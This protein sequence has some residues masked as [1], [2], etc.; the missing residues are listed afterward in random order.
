M[1]SFQLPSGLTSHLTCGKLYYRT[2]LLDEAR[3]SLYVGA[4]DR[5]F[6]VNLANVSQTDCQQDSLEL[7][8]SNTANCISKGKSEEFDC[9]NHV[10]VIQ[11]IDSGKRLYICGTNAHN[12]KDQVRQTTQQSVVL[13]IQSTTKVFF[14]QCSAKPLSLMISTELRGKAVCQFCQFLLPLNMAAWSGL[15]DQ[16]RWSWSRPPVSECSKLDL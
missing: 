14:Y 15:P 3:D 11:L 9:R 4:M 5:I 2:V 12:P 7:E 8:P 1:N 13:L 10:R 16:L 6:R